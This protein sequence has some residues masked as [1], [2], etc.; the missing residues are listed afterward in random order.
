MNWK[1]VGTLSLFG[2]AMGIATVFVIPSNIEPAFWLAIFLVCGFLISKRA[3]GKHFLHGLFTSLLNSVWITGAHVAF[4]DTYVANH[5]QEAAMMQNMPVAGRLAMVLTG[6]LVGLISGLLLGL[7]AFVMS[8]F[9][10][11]A[12]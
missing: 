1:L 5:P 2:L 9:I 12:V 4:F 8:R 11:P 3:P 10:K 6:P 7:I